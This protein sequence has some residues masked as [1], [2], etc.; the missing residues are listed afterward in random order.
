MGTLGEEYGHC[1]GPFRYCGN[2]ARGAPTAE[3]VETP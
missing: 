1:L 2:L 3:V